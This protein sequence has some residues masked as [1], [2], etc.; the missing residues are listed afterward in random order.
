MKH[1]LW[2][3]ILSAALVLGM[4]SVNTSY[5]KTTQQNIEDAKNQINSLQQQKEEAQEEVD[6]ISDKKGDIEANLNGLNGELQNIASS[7]N[8]LEGEIETKETEIARAQDELAAAELR[9]KEQY[10]DMKVRIRFIYENSTASAWQ[11]LLEASSM[12]DF[13]NRTEYISQ[14]NTYDRQKLDEFQRVQQEIAEQKAGLEADMETLVAMQDEMK[15]NQKR[16]NSLISTA[17]AN[18]AQTNEELAQAQGDVNELE[19]KLADMIAYEQKLEEQKARED[20][21]RLEAI[22]QQEQEDT[23]GVVYVPTDSD[24]YLLGAIIQCESEG[25]PYAGKLA[26]GLEAIKQQEQ[27]DTSGVVYVPTDSDAYLLGAIIQCES[28]GEPYAGKLA[29]GSVVLNRVKSS[30]FPNTISGVIYQSG[31]FSPVASGR[32]AYRL[33]AGVNNE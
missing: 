11:T 23:S 10:E 20:A 13:L 17:Q 7:M 12:K 4:L 1:I 33:Q 25:E 19:K 27:E 28:E 24:A 31:Q 6:D 30:Y 21:A 26:V 32:L 5:A 9:S 22:K 3:R 2:K 29:V 15:Q 8:K 14:I 16:V 18:L